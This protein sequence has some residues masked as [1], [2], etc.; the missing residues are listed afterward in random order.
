ML[1]LRLSFRVDTLP[2]NWKFSPQQQLEQHHA[3]SPNASG[4]AALLASSSP[5]V[6]SQ[7]DLKGA[8]AATLAGP[9]SSSGHASGPGG[10]ESNGGGS[11]GAG[12][13]D[14]M[15]PLGHG[16]I[17]PQQVL[18]VLLP[19]KTGLVVQDNAVSFP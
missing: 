18:Q 9:E 5:C 6:A 14:L 4:A 12:V 1:P 16:Q 10:A 2:V 7:G 17:T 13:N 19:A 15:Q 8:G 11:S 3:N